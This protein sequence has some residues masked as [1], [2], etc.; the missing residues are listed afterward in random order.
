MNRTIR[1]TG[2]AEGIG[3]GT[4][5]VYK[6][7]SRYVEETHI[8]PEACAQ[9]LELWHRTKEQAAEELRALAGHAGD[10]DS[11]AIMEAHIEILNDDEIEEMVCEAITSD[12]ASAQWAVQSSFETFIVLLSDTD[13]AL[14][15]Q[16]VSDLRDVRGRLLRVLAGGH[17]CDLSS[18][19]EGTVIV[20]HDLF[21]S[22]TAALDK[23]HVAGIVTEMGG[24]TSH[25]AILARSYRLPAVLGAGEVLPLVADGEPIIV[26]SEAGEVLLQPDAALL[27]RYQDKKR[28]TELLIAQASAYMTQPCVLKS[29]E[30]V[31]IG[32]NVGG[33]VPEELSCCDFVGLF[34]TEF[35]YMDADHLP[36]EEEQFTAYRDLLLAAEEKCV[37][38]R[39]L[40]I[41]GDKQL[42][43][44]ELPHEANPFL[45][46]RAIRLCFDEPELFRTQLRAACRASAYGRLQIMFP[47]ISSVEDW[48]RAKAIT[49]DVM[50]ELEREG[51]DYD[52]DLK[53]GIMIEI[54]ATALIPDI[55]AAEVDFV[56]VGTN[57]LC[58]YL[59]AADRLEPSVSGYYQSFSPAFLR[60]LRMIISAF[61]AAGKEV[62]M[63]GELAGDAKAAALLAG[64]GLRKFS[65]SAASI[66]RVK[67]ALAGAELTGA[68]TLAEAACRV[69]TQ[70]EVLYLLEVG[71]SGSAE[72]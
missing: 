6:P 13:N 52:R 68:S 41:G 4:V 69:K 50:Q 35:L 70:A 1:G 71:R 31:S 2:T 32:L 24:A 66:G 48:R 57:D 51:I 28:Q 37:T 22:D 17:T 61:H 64:L 3:I 15:A 49:Q 18:L 67:Q 53:L 44:M 62:S 47:M 34:R 19:P 21:P 60:A 10:P 40:D 45:G 12:S 55:L 72:D 30:R 46:R 5:F 58:Q 26:D 23:Q 54:P 38:L 27:Q 33:E 7:E 56:S 65:M 29:G 36:T 25:T 16:R 42:K 43:Y 59:C 39:T 8:A 14:I 9:E 11:R 20:T 63:C